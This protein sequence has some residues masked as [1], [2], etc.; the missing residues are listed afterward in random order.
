MDRG[1]G[2]GLETAILQIFVVLGEGSILGC[3]VLLFLLLLPLGVHLDF[4]RQ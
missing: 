1:G 3:D 2:S 4:G